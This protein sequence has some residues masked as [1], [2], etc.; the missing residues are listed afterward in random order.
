GVHLLNLLTIPAIVMVYYFR[1]YTPTVKGGMIAFLIGCAL[2][3]FVQFGIIQVVPILASKFELLFVNSFGLPFNTGAI[4][5]VL[6]LVAA[7]VW[8]IIWAKKKGRY[9]LHLATLCI[10][11]TLIGYSSYV[12]YLIRAKL[13]IPINIGAPDNV[14]SLIPFLQRDQY[15]SVP[16]VSGPD[17]DAR[18][19]AVEEGSPVYAATEKDG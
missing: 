9:F 2:L 12:T 4:F 11:F 3:G 7:I 5:F 10:A 1:K 18:L 6:L 17:F 8:V 16:L 13:S 14:M 19:V 15:G